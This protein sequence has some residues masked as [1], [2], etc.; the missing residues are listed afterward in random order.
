M[1]QHRTEHKGAQIVGQGP[2]HLDVT[3]WATEGI[4]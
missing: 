1:M 2:G 4:G 3:A